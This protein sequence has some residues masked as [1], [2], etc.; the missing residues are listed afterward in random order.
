MLLLTFCF[1]SVYSADVIAGAYYRAAFL[2]DVAAVLMLVLASVCF[3]VAIVELERRDQAKPVDDS[4][5]E[6]LE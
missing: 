5:S 2:S 3:T 6:P 1:F 4:N